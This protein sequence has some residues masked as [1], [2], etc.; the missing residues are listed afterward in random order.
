MIKLLL[1]EEATLTKKNQIHCRR[2]DNFLI[3]EVCK[4]I[5]QSNEKAY[6][7][8]KIAP[9]LNKLVYPVQAQT[10]SLA[11]ECRID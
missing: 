5:A 10:E 11:P 7:S 3:L 2:T 4:S 6:E 8:T 1:R 9:S